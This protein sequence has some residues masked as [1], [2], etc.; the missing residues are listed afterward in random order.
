M[1]KKKLNNL[2]VKTDKKLESIRRSAG[3]GRNHKRPDIPAKLY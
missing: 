1:K 2:K 3:L